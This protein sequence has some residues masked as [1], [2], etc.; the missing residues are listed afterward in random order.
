MR[1][2]PGIAPL[3]PRSMLFTLYGD[4]AYPRG[5]D[6]WLGSLVALGERLG[7]SEVAVRSAVAR[8]AR[9]G[10]IVARRDGNR[11]H[12]AL[13]DAGRRLIEEGTRRIYRGEGTA[14][15][16]SWCMLTY[17][18]P[19]AKR[20]HRD[21]LR[22]QLAWLGFGPLGGGTYVSPRDVSSEAE[23]LVREHGVETFSRIFSARLSGP[24]SEL[25]LVRQCWD[26]GAIEA[27]YETFLRH[28]AP[29]YAR[30]LRRHRTASLP[31]A[32]AF[33]HRFA[34]THD[35]RRFPFVDPD[36]PASLLPRE[37]AGGRARSL[38]EAHHALLTQGA[39]RFFSSIA[40]LG[41][42]LRAG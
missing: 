22:K 13:S 12:Y 21:R 32:A 34:L 31:D 36:L 15:N 42:R 3:R 37:W 19:E 5:V 39:Q 26:V 4:Y 17:S 2:F 38:F 8:L 27:Q 18:I 24:G 11:S 23:E 28:Y 41:A 29:L 16:G 9:D 7:I 25:D 20:A 30:D 33:V 10:W 35:F 40:S 14:W 1:Q 6:L